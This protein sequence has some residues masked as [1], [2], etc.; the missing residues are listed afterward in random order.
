MR[1]GLYLFVLLVS[2]PLQ[3]ELRDPTRPGGWLMAVEPD[4]DIATQTLSLSAIF[5]N[6]SGSVAMINGRSYRVGDKVGNH[7]LRIIEAD[8]VVL[9]S[10][11]GQVELNLT[12]PLVKQRHDMMQN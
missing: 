10:V 3:A 5:F 8:R 2:L 11:D 12:V 6:P 4:A 9:D 7:I 1:Y